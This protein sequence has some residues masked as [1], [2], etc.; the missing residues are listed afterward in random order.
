MG[1]IKP[2]NYKTEMEAF[3]ESGCSI[4]PQFEYESNERAT[5]YLKSFQKPRDNL[6]KLSERILEEF[7]REYGD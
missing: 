6:L 1:S 4:N 7:H 5:Q 3:L 2:K